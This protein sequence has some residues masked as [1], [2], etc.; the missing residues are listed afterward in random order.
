MSKIKEERNMLV[1]SRKL[2]EAIVIDGSI[3]VSI[4][5]VDGDRVK[6]GIAAPAEIPVHRQEV[7][8]KIGDYPSRLRFADC[9]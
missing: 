3:T 8:Q 1:L 5:A 2:G 9:A 6:L 4:L 7:S